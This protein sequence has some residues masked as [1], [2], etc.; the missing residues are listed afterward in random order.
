M[1][2]VGDGFIYWQSEHSLWT[3]GYYKPD[4]KREPLSDWGDPDE[5][6]REVHFLNG[7]C[8]AACGSTEEV[9]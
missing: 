5:A 9:L 8:T 2:E 7:G 4:G 3:V 6:R 1:A